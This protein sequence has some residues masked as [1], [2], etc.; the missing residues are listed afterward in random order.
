[1]LMLPVRPIDSFHSFQPISQEPYTEHFDQ[2][3]NIRYI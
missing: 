2:K 3:K 1:M